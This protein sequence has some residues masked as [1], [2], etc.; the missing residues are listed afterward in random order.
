MAGGEALGTGSVFL[1]VTQ[2]AESS[3]IPGISTPS[4]ALW[5]AK[6]AQKHRVPA[7]RRNANLTCANVGSDEAQLLWGSG[8]ARGPPHHTAAPARREAGR[9]CAIIPGWEPCGWLFRWLFSPF[10]A[11][12]KVPGVRFPGCAQL[13]SPAFA[14]TEQPRTEPP[15]SPRR[16]P[17]APLAPGPST[18]PFLRLFPFQ[19]RHTPSPSGDFP[20]PTLFSGQRDIAPLTLQPQPP[21]Y[22]EE[23]I[24]AS[25]FFFPSDPRQPK[26]GLGWGYAAVPLP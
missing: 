1:G 22:Q 24:P 8:A 17:S 21:Y 15:R 23:K 10:L 26:I 4:K 13:L 7:K 20:F 3:H 9:G 12:S 19:S 25:R 11:L 5:P 16:L 2:K 18:G 14:G 6:K